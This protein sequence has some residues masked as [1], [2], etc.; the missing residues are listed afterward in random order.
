MK[1]DVLVIGSGIAGLSFAIKVAAAKPDAIIHVLTKSN[2]DVG[3][4]TK[5]QGGIAV[6]LDK[7]RDSFE[8][9][10]EDTMKAGKGI[11]D[12]EVVKLVISQAPERLYELINWGTS[13]D[14]NEL[15]ELELGLEGG[16][17]Q[18]RI[19]H[20]QDL[21]GK[22]METKLLQ[23]AASYSNIIF[24][25]HYF[26]TDLILKK[27]ESTTTCIGV[28][29]I[30]RQKAEVVSIS[31]RVTFLATGGSGRI[32]QNT[33]N[34]S[35]ATGDGIAMAYR[36]GA[37]ILNMNFIQFHPTALY[38]KNQHS[39]FLI[40]EAVRGFGAYVID[41][42]GNRFLFKYDANGEL[43]TRDIVSEAI[44]KELQQSGK[45]SVFLDCRHL[46]AEAFK[47]HFPTIVQYCLDEG[48]DFKKDLLPIVPAAH[49]QCGGIQVDKFARTSINKLYASGECAHTGLHG[50]NRLASNSL[51]EALVFSHQ[52][53]GNVVEKLDSIPLEE[54]E[55]EV[56]FQIDVSKEESDIL[57]NFEK[58]LNRLMSYNLLYTSEENE[59][60]RV[61]SKLKFLDEKIEKLCKN[62]NPEFFELK[63]MIQTAMIVLEHAI[64]SKFLNKKETH[65][66]SN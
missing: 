8:Q 58:E 9:H 44:M 49:Y 55:Q 35:V 53:A 39:L 3:N 27:E 47:S 42:A 14:A 13:F 6:V 48:I 21:T 65:K 20:H 10:I 26:V 31:S 12:P 60:Q 41:S 37:E 45:E 56:I 11:N 50:A 17:S 2:N 19:V 43:A 29:A 22:E 62:S 52:A 1:T 63:N 38:T 4:T 66:F 51:L 33:T 24:C 28:R 5:A 23:K 25:D 64:K 57:N 32:F 61:L 7:I 40:S 16:H 15:G 18:K 59:K 46:E 36:A 30:D 54:C 34:P